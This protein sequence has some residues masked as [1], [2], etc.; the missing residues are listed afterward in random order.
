MF[1]VCDR[2][3]ALLGLTAALGAGAASAR[4][5]PGA[6][7]DGVWSNGSYTLLERPKEFTRLVATEAEAA[8][9]EAPRRAL[10]GIHPDEYPLGQAESE[11]PET[12]PG[13]ARIRGEIRTSW[14]TE[15][16]DGRIPWT[17]QAR[18]R[19]GIGKPPVERFDH[20]EERPT[21]ERCITS[22][23]SFAPI[24]NAPDTNYFQIVQTPAHVAIVSEKNHD[25]RI[26]RLGAAPP[27]PGV[28]PVWMGHATGRW[29]GRTLVVENRRMRFTRVRGLILTESARVV[30]RIS[31]SG[32]D[33]LAYLF[34]VTDPALFT[35]TWRGEMAFRRA[36][37]PLYEFACHEGNY[38]LPS[39]LSAA[40]QGQQRPDNTPPRADRVN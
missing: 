35:T 10:K 6:D 23:G 36:D 40:R 39:I 3:Q 29:H 18:E 25:A 9:W 19:Y 24:M 14:I 11:F 32:P 38:S 31:R 21:D 37:K 22:R 2:R 28:A 13:L 30:E 1:S 8:A 16:A 33:E 34:E 12:G 17:P 7:L 27:P 5:A 26:V 15:P 4:P 20:I